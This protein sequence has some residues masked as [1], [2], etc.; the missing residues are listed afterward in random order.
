MKSRRPASFLIDTSPLLPIIEPERY[1]QYCSWLLR[2]I[3]AHLK[4]IGGTDMIIVE[5]FLNLTVLIFLLSIPIGIIL[6]IIESLIRIKCHDLYM[7]YRFRGGSCWGM[8]PCGHPNCRLRHFCPM[9]QHALT[10]EV[11]AELESLLEERRKEIE[12]EKLQ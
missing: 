2:K 3:T 6:N 4:Y 8:K 1:R 10:P 7:Q 12:K 9:Y 5:F 11:M